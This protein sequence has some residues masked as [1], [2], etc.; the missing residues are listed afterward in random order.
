MIH[1]LIPN[2]NLITSH[3]TFLRDVSQAVEVVAFETETFLVISKSGS[4]LDSEESELDEREEEYNAQGLSLQR[5]ERISEMV[6]GFRK[7]CQ[8]VRTLNQ[9]CLRFP[10]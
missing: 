7:T 3:L 4:T 10:S 9:V 8:C 5:F 1:T 2:I 6:K